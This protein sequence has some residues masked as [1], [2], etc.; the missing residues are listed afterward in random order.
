VKTKE[1]GTLF[2]GTKEVKIDSECCS[3][4]QAMLI[5]VSER[6]RTFL[7][8]LEA[9]NSL[10]NDNTFDIEDVSED[11]EYIEMVFR[12]KHHVDIESWIRRIRGERRSG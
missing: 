1:D 8:Q 9:A 5:V 6:L 11:E 12:F 10:L 7:P 2:P 3:P 4:L